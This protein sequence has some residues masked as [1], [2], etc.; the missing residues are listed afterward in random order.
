MISCHR[1]AIW[2]LAISL[3][4]WLPPTYPLAAR[5]DDSQQTGSLDRVD[6]ELRDVRWQLLPNRVAKVATSPDGRVW[7]VLNKAPDAPFHFVAETKKIVEREFSKPSPQLC[8]I[9]RLFFEAESFSGPG[10][11]KLRRVWVSCRQGHGQPNVLVGYD[12]K[13]WTEPHEFDGNG[14]DRTLTTSTGMIQLQDALVFVNVLGA[15]VFRDG[16]WSLQGL[17]PSVGRGTNLGGKSIK[18][19]ATW[20]LDEGQELILS[21]RRPKMHKFG[22]RRSIWK[23]RGGSW[24]EIK[25]P[26]SYRVEESE[27][28]RLDDSFVFA[29][30]K[31]TLTRIVDGKRI[32]GTIRTALIRLSTDGEVTELSSDE[33]LEVGQYRVEP[34]YPVFNDSAGRFY[35]NCRDVKKRSKSLG[36]GLIVYADGKARFYPAGKGIASRLRL[37]SIRPIGEGSLAWAR[38]FKLVPEGES[39]GFQALAVLVDLDRMEVVHELPHATFKY[40]CTAADGTVFAHYGRHETWAAFRPEAE[41]EQ[42][43]LVSEPIRLQGSRGV[44]IAGDGGIWLAGGERGPQR[45]NGRRWELPFATFRGNRIIQEWSAALWMVPGNDDYMLCMAATAPRYA[46]KGWAHAQVFLFKGKEFQVAMPRFIDTVRKHPELIGKAFDGPQMLKPWF[47]RKPAMPVESSA[48]TGKYEAIEVRGAGV[49]ITKQGDI[50]TNTFGKV[51]VAVGEEQADLTL[52]LDPTKRDDRQD[53]IVLDMTLMPGDEDVFLQVSDG[54]T[55][56]ARLES[57]EF[58]L[59]E[60][61]KLA[62]GGNWNARSPFAIQDGEG[63]VWVMPES[64]KKVS[65]RHDLPQ[66][67]ETV[68]RYLSLEEYEDF[69][70]IGVPILADERGCIWLGDSYGTE[71]E[72]ITVWSPDGETSTITIPGRIHDSPTFVGGP[73]RVFVWTKAGLQSFLAE[74]PAKPTEYVPGPVSHLKSPYGHKYTKRDV[75][76]RY[77]KLGFIAVC[78]IDGH[79]RDT[80]NAFVY[81][82]GA[83]GKSRKKAKREAKK[84]RKETRSTPAGEKTMPDSKAAAIDGRSPKLRTWKSKSGRSSVDAEFIGVKDGKVRLRKA[85]GKTVSIALKKLSDADRE[86][87]ERLQATQ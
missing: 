57:G 79:R 45:F 18:G 50:W 60:G 76:F 37:A 14:Y 62:R 66:E 51:R 33:M 83:I 63:G 24:T 52:P 5:A 67:G 68:R 73:G 56:F 54:R 16:V 28:A 20:V 65:R 69:S 75:D 47:A 21:P 81:P 19:L 31:H 3:A 22:V 77:S 11:K 70:D 49:V 41:E 9:Q 46:M 32:P 23:Y 72:R 74:D 36:K 25:L 59:T 38:I 44:A 8:D 64:D 39:H 4:A 12:G 40:T 27:C 17:M 86:V 55:Y 71:M 84:P 82:V 2:I 48:R 42:E 85:N 78:E 61:P 87:V 58:D 29:Q 13:S 35:V 6:L 7:T 43:V 10:N 1:K 26:E 15:H 30:I 80:R 34:D 53:A